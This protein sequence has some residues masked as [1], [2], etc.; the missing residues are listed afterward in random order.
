MK[1]L[2]MLALALALTGCAT[3]QPTEPA[4][5]CALSRFL[6]MRDETIVSIS[7]GDPEFARAVRL[8]NQTWLRECKR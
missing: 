1:K 6:P 7:K 5:Y 8:H 3:S 4:A 2:A